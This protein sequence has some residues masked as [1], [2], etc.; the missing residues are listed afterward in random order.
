MSNY[1][2]QL[3][4]RSRFAA[5]QHKIIIYCALRKLSCNLSLSLAAGESHHRDVSPPFSR[6]HSSLGS[7]LNL[8][9]LINALYADFL[10]AT[11]L[12]LQM[13]DKFH[14]ISRDEHDY[15]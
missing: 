12:Q 4:S 9:R 15:I 6:A 13:N 5:R 11:M 8:V 2:Y 10:M 14:V 7:H 1:D 3:H